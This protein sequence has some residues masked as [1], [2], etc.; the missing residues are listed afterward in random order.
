ME[1]I[2]PGLGDPVLIVITANGPSENVTIPVDV[3]PGWI[4]STNLPNTNTSLGDCV[5]ESSSPTRLV[6]E[7]DPVISVRD[8]EGSAQFGI[9][10]ISI[11]LLFYSN[12][13]IPNTIIPV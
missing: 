7:K 11:K 2:V 12:S 13:I 6:D 4:I 10:L 9:I 1:V 8:I 5:I 3:T